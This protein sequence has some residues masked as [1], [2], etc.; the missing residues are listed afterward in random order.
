MFIFCGVGPKLPL[1]ALIHL[2]ERWRV[3]V[4]S[5]VENSHSLFSTTSWVRFAHSDLLVFI[6]GGVGPKVLLEGIAIG[7]G[8]IL[9]STPTRGES[10]SFPFKTSWVLSKILCGR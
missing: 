10:H 3:R 1:E 9:P 4:S 7:R 2:V 6:P 5:F 8:G